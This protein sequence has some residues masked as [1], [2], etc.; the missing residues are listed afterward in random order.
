M[1]IMVVIGFGAIFLVG[2]IFVIVGKSMDKKKETVYTPNITPNTSD[3]FDC[4]LIKKRIL[5]LQN[6]PN[7]LTA[8][9][10]ALT[11]QFQGVAETLVLR[12]ILA[13]NKLLSEAYIGEEGVFEALTKKNDAKTDYKLACDPK[14][15]RLKKTDKVRFFEKSIAEKDASI[16]KLKQTKD[17]P[18]SEVEK[19]KR[20]KDTEFEKF[21]IN[22]EDKKRREGYEFEE[23]LKARN[24]RNEV[25]ERMEKE[26]IERECK[27]HGVS[28]VTDLPVQEFANLQRVLDDLKDKCFNASDKSDY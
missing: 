19:H 15:Q 13:Q 5:E 23:E 18:D 7:L 16:Q 9:V 26:T 3:D 10:K 12:Q 2:V 21:K 28:K 11:I 17:D 1:S 14:I 27:K 8:Y 25:Y 24:V 20:K 22:K 4:D 6:S